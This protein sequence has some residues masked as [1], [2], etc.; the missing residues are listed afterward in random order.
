MKTLEHLMLCCFHT[1]LAYV[2]LE[3]ICV[4]SSFDLQKKF[5]TVIFLMANTMS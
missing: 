4:F 5:V 2:D 3:C 1:L